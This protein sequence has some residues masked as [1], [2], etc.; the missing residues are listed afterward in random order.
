MSSSEAKHR[1]GNTM[2]SN[3]R[4]KGRSNEVGG[5][6]MKHRKEQQNKSTNNKTQKGTI[7]QEEE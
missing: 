1:V 6:A 3:K 2:N 4:N 5:G 7:K